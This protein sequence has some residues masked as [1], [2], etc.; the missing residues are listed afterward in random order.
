MGVDRTGKQVV[1]ESSG[2]VFFHIK[3]K[4]SDEILQPR[5]GTLVT[6]TQP[7]PAKELEM[8]RNPEMIAAQQVTDDEMKKMNEEIGIMDTMS[9]EEKFNALLEK[10]LVALHYWHF[11]ARTGLWEA[12]PVSGF[13]TDIERGVYVMKAPAFY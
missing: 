2:L 6:I 4:N 10:N 8:M 9:D 1:L 7:I 12:W 3:E 13:E 5:K 11:N